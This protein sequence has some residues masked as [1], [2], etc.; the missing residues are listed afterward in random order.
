MKDIELPKADQ[1]NQYIEDYYKMTE[2]TRNTEDCKSSPFSR[3]TKL[4]V[5]PA[6]VPNHFTHFGEKRTLCP[7]MF[8]AS[9]FAARGQ[10]QDAQLEIQLQ[11]GEPTNLH[12]NVCRA[13]P[14]FFHSSFFI[15]QDDFAEINLIEEDSEDTWVRGGMP[16]RQLFRDY[17]QMKKEEC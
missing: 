6:L 8:T 17:L 11:S 12:E 16:S 1:R 4:T 3:A 7:R 10:L 5:K 13:E 9:P 15:H 14:S 2:I